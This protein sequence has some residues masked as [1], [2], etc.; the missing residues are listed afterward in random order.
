MATIVS[1]LTLVLLDLGM[2]ESGVYYGNP[3]SL[4]IC[5]LTSMT[6]VKTVMTSGLRILVL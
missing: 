4:L 1:E 6:V 3:V 5:V 2:T